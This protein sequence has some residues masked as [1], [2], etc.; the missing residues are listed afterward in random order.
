MKRVNSVRDELAAQSMAN[1]IGSE[2]VGAWRSGRI[3]SAVRRAWSRTVSKFF[4]AGV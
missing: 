3:A 2:T 4:L 1:D